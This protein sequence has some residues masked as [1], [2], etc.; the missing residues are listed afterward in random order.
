MSLIAINDAVMV[1]EKDA[2]SF[3]AEEKEFIISFAFRTNSKDRTNKLMADIVA[4]NNE[5]A[6]K[7]IMS[8]Y[9]SEE[10]DNPKWI[11]SIEN[12]LISLEMYR[13]EEEKAINR[14]SNILNAYGIDVSYDE[15]SNSKPDQIRQKVQEGIGDR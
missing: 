10:K 2:H 7:D 6:S 14:L 5:Q 1:M 13:I 9:R 12:L 15:I 3:T 4:A 8:R 11:E